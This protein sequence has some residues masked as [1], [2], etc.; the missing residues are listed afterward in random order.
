MNLVKGALRDTT[1][2]ISHTHTSKA[3]PRRM[4]RTVRA[5]DLGHSAGAYSRMDEEGNGNGGIKLQTLRAGEISKTTTTEVRI[6]ELET[7]KDEGYGTA[8]KKGDGCSRGSSEVY[9]I[10]RPGRNGL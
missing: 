4:S 1:A 2:S 8:G 9:I 6:D 10:E 7:E 3:R 5:T